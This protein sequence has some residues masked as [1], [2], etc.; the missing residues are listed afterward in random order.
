[1]CKKCSLTSADLRHNDADSKIK[2]LQ[3]RVLLLWVFIFIKNIH[4][5]RMQKKLMDSLLAADR[6]RTAFKE[7]AMICGFSAVMARDPDIHSVLEAVQ[8]TRASEQALQVHFP[9][10]FLMSAFLY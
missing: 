10:S 1:M 7:I 5:P 6:W 2:E 9:R 4:L 3:V 8:R